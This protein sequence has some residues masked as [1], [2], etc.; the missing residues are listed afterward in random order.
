MQRLTSTSRT[1]GNG[2]TIADGYGGAMTPTF[3]NLDN[4]NVRLSI[5]STNSTTWTVKV[6]E[7]I[8]P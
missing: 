4:N 8:V 3:A 1:V 5:T 6:L 7:R 2:A